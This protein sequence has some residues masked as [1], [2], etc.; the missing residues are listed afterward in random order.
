[1]IGDALPP[2]VDRG[3]KVVDEAA[4]VRDIGAVIRWAE[5]FDVCERFALGESGDEVV[6][7]DIG[8]FDD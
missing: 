6:D 5:D 3:T 1:M 8:P 7:C 4:A 2:G